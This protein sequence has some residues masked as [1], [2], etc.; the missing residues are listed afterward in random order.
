MKKFIAI[1]AIA[2]AGFAGFSFVTPSTAEAATCHARSPSATGW[3]QGSWRYARERALY[4]CA[5]RT[6]RGQT[7]YITH[8]H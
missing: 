4:E 5:I 2:F 7:C 1:A 6:P 8:C 3:G